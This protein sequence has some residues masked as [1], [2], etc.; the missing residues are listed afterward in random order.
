MDGVSAAQGAA[1]AGAMAVFPGGGKR[2]RLREG[3]VERVGE[4]VV[5][6]CRA[7]VEWRE[8]LLAVEPLF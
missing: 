8:G 3:R 7:V 1:A 6:L 4:R 2:L 5:F